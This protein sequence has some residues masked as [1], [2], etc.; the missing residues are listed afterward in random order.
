MPEIALN[1]PP[2]NPRL[3]GVHSRA[4]HDG[5]EAEARIVAAAATARVGDRRERLDA[6][7]VVPIPLVAAKRRA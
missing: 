3:R 4:Q 7:I 2:F 6:C 1:P 5:E